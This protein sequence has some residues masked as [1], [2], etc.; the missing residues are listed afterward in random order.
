MEILLEHVWLHCN[1]YKTMN[2]EKMFYGMN[3]A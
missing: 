1:L 3:V 2:E